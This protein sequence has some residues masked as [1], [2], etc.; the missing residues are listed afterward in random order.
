MGNNNSTGGKSRRDFLSIFSLHDKK[1]AAP[2]MV[3]MLT[4]DGKLV[5]VDKAM[6]DK[7]MKNKKASNQEI[8]DWMKNPSKENQ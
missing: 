5:S 8:F 4:P 1:A 7:A 2:E 6:L 3:K